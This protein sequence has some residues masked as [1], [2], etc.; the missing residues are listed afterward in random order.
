M[1]AYY[2][3]LTKATIWREG[4]VEEGGSGGRREGGRREGGR[5]GGVE[6]GG[7]L[8]SCD[9]THLILLVRPYEASW[10]Y[11]VGTNIKTL[12]HNNIALHQV[13]LSSSLTGLYCL[14]DDSK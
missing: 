2:S 9:L 12:L 4:G 6:E 10:I 7:S 14:R 8:L 3:R 5:E 11:T 1:E 13:S